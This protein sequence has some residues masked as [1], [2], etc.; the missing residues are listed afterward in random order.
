MVTELGRLAAEYGDTIHL[1]ITD[2]VMPGMTGRELATR[3]VA[4]RPGIRC[5]FISGYTAD[6]VAKRGVLDAG[7]FFLPKPFDREQLALNVR[8]GLKR[9]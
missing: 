9:T 4:Q 8:E 3:V 2:V 1:L 5:L 6:V 7:L